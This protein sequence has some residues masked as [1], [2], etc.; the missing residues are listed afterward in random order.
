MQIELSTLISVVSVGA[1]VV[2]GYI[3]MKRN[4]TK[5][6]EETVEERATLLTRVMTK[7]DTI[8]DSLNEIKRDNKDIR[9]DINSLKERVLILE[10]ESKSGRT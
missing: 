2:F 7:L 3:A 1:A 6:I 9:A 8:T 10:Q 5:D 4:N